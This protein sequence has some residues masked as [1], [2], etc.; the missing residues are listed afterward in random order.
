MKE[1]NSSAPPEVPIGDN[2]D[3]TTEQNRTFDV[4]S[5]FRTTE[6]AREDALRLGREAPVIDEDS[7][8]H[9]LDEPAQADP[10]VQETPT[11]KPRSRRQKT[12]RGLGSR[13]LL[14]ADGPPPG[15]EDARK[16][17]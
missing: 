6:Q 4:N 9:P 12:R 2:P 10:A 13:Q 15:V 7:S 16:T 1:I 14:Q 8:E 5:G 3:W 11:T 17:Y